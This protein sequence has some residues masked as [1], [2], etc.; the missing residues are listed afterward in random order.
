[1]L[2]PLTPRGRAKP[3]TPTNVM[4]IMPFGCDL[5][6]YL[7]NEK[8]YI[9]AHNLR[10]NQVISIG[11]EDRVRKIMSD[12]D[13]H[14]FM[15][16]YIHTCPDDYFEQIA[17]VRNME[18]QTVVFKA[19]DIFRCQV[20]RQHYAYG[21]ILGKTRELEKW[22]E[23][24]QE[25]T[26]RSAMMQ[27]IIVRMYDFVTTDKNMTTNM[28]LDK[29]LCPPDLCSDCDI[30]WGTHKIVAH[31]ELVPND[32]QFQLQLARQVVKN[33]HI[34]PFTAETFAKFSSKKNTPKTLYVEWGFSSFEI[35]WENVPEN[36]RELLDEGS[37]FKAGVSMGI[38]ADMCGKTF[39]DTLKGTPNHMIQNNLLLPQNRNK[40]NLVMKFLGLPN[41]CTLDDFVAKYGGISRQEYI[42]LIHERCK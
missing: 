31:K 34:T 38:S 28:L 37:Y 22:A 30:L 27:P 41:D 7:R 21:I 25:H 17:D 32:I 20:D 4:A 12:E 9:Y 35:P 18:H 42:E 23:L 1:M 29:K 36:I 2:L 15:G 10:N 5:Y 13:F 14:E 19:G 6:I 40:F 11:E 3:I 39:D 24:P 26:F 16:Y 8:S 33:E